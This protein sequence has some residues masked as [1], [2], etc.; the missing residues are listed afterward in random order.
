MC[1]MPTWHSVTRRMEKRDRERGE[2]LGKQTGLR[3]EDTSTDV[4]DDIGGTPWQ[5]VLSMNSR[6]LFAQELMQAVGGPRVDAA[7]GGEPAAA[8]GEHAVAEVVE[9]LSLVHVAVDRKQAPGV[10]G[11]FDVRVA[12]V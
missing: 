8:G 6:A 2:G 10:D 7:I 1:D 11:G 4:A 12:Q 9:V 5:R 3:D